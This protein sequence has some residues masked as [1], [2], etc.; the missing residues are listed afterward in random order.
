MRAV[1]IRQSLVLN[2]YFELS[3]DGLNS[4]V[5]A[6]GQGCKKKGESIIDGLEKVTG[7]N[8]DQNIIDEYVII[9]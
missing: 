3:Q 8:Y 4:I 2:E 6:D 7:L 1:R 9:H 5:A